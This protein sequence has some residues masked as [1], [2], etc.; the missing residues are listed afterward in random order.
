MREIL[1]P[2]QT[3]FDQG[4]EVALATVVEIYGSAPRGLGAT[5]P[6]LAR[7]RGSRLPHHLRQ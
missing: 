6:A 5:Y 3:W 1:Q 4:K 7:P 2:M